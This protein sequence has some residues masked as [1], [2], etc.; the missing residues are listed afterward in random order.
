VLSGEATLNYQYGRL[1][2]CGTEYSKWNVRRRGVG[3]DIEPNNYVTVCQVRKRK[4]IGEV[5]VERL[6]RYQWRGTS[7]EVPLERY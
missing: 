3:E 6:Q 1:R 4:S 2:W 7:G 5:P